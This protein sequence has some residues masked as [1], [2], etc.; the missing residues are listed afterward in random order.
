[1]GTIVESRIDRRK[2]KATG[3]RLL[4]SYEVDNGYYGGER[5]AFVDGLFTAS[6]E[7][8]ADKYPESRRVTVRYAPDRPEISVLEAGV[9]WIGFA[10]A[11]AI[12][13]SAIGCFGLRSTIR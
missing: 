5:I 7:A 1:M 8:G 10:T 11:A 9:S 2:S 4:Y 3:Q 12:V 13:F 6:P